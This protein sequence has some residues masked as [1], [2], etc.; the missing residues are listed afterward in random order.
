MS[1]YVASS[2]ISA[3]FAEIIEKLLLFQNY[4]IRPEYARRESTLR[5]VELLLEKESSVYRFVTV[6]ELLRLGYPNRT[7]F[8]NEGDREWLGSLKRIPM[9]N[10]SRV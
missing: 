2:P 9:V 6:P 3:V 10:N 4:A 1:G 5:A 8:L 7:L